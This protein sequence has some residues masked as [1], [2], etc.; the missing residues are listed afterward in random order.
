MPK[1]VL[2]LYEKYRS[3]EMREGPSLGNTVRS[4]PAEIGEV[5]GEA[6]FIFNL[7]SIAATERVLRAHVHLYKRKSTHRKRR[8]SRMRTE[9]ELVLYE[10]APHYLSQTGSI[11]MRSSAKGWQW[12]GAT[13][14]VL[15]CLLVDRQHPHL[16]ALSFR[17]EK[18]NGKV[19]T[20]ALKRFVRHHS[21]PFL[22]LY[23]NE[24]ESVNLEELDIVAERLK[25]KEDEEFPQNQDEFDEEEEVDEE[26]E[27]GD[28]EDEDELDRD[29]EDMDYDYDDIDDVFGRDV[30]GS[31]EEEEEEE[32]DRKEEEESSVDLDD[33]SE[34]RIRDLFRGFGSNR[35]H[36]K[37]QQKTG[38]NKK[39]GHQRRYNKN[40]KSKLD[41]DDL[42]KPKSASKNF[43]K[44]D[45]DISFEK[46]N[47]DESFEK[48]NTDESF[49]KSNSDE[50]FEKA[51]SDKSLEKSDS[52]TT[53]NTV[54]DA[55]A[56]SQ[57]HRTKLKV[58]TKKPHSDSSESRLPSS[59]R[60]RKRSILTNEIPEDPSDYP[61]YHYRFNLPQTHPGMLTARKD[62]RHQEEESR[63]IPYPKERTQSRNKSQQRRR[64]K[65]RKRKNR[66]RNR[67]NRRRIRIPEEWEDYHDNLATPDNNPGQVCARRRL[68][69]DF[70]DI[71]WG[72]WI[73][74][75]KSFEAHY[76]SGSCPFPLTKRLRPSNHATIQSIVNAIGLYSGVPAPCCVPDTMTSVTLLYFDENRNVVLKNYPGMSV[77][78]CA[79]R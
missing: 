73:I 27:M 68:V 6:M 41:P 32:E 62:P 2:D 38:H 22:I 79:C 24:T 52:S 72:D 14:A 51:I 75:P 31:D 43:E 21:L 25:Q 77:Q 70:A 33:L 9:T 23:S 30:E 37:K 60:R 29:V 15:S 3:G 39:Q 57:S 20:L 42:I 44:A 71:G 5:N 61:K 74:S 18:P 16:F 49:E 1:Y 58:S 28:D 35:Q 47:T 76:C 66:R 46:S 53:D 8:G 11:I 48:S 54:V 50:S 36:S 12:Y 13:D 19:R 10:V 56:A 65:H 34:D 26:E 63:I 4:I 67:K 55:A 64:R 40:N 69:V 78:S 45:A 59:Q 7:S 17:A